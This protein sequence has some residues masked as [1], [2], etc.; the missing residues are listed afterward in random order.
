MPNARSRSLCNWASRCF[1]SWMMA[2]QLQRL[3]AN[4][5]GLLSAS[6]GLRI[7]RLHGCCCCSARPLCCSSLASLRLLRLL[8]T[9]PC[10][11][12]CRTCCSAALCQLSP[13]VSRSFPC[14]W[15]ASACV[16]LLLQPPPLTGLPG[17]IVCPF[18]NA[19]SLRCSR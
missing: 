10:W 16:L 7:C 4:H 9:Q 12:V 5:A 18:S 15:G 3:S 8:M 11:T 14:A 19:S 13:L 2:A 17:P 1:P 6:V